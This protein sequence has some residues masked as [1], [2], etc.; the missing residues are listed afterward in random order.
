MTIVGGFYMDLS[1]VPDPVIDF[2]LFPEPEVTAADVEDRESLKAFVLATIEVYFQ[3]VQ[4]HGLDVL[5]EFMNVL[6]A[7]EGPYRHGSVYLFMFD[8]NGYVIF[9][10]V[11]RALE[12]QIVLHVEDTNGLKFVQELI[13][14]ARMDGGGFVEYYFDDPSVEGDED[15]GSPKISYV[16]LLIA[17]DNL[18][19]VV[20]AG[21]YPDSPTSVDRRSWGQIK[22]GMR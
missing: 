17:N 21:L 2:S 3:A 7:E 10:G 5:R 4:E 1:M 11:S 19:F 9:H 13:E 22:R 8:T 20:G 6:R 16:E 18:E 14:V 12:N 15:T